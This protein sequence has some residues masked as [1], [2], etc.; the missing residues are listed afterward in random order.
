MR[1]Q[2]RQRDANGRWTAWE[3]IPSVVSFL[4]DHLTMIGC[5]RVTV[6]YADGSKC[7]WRRVR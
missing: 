4:S 5:D 3:T 7:Q 1:Y 2:F 6:R